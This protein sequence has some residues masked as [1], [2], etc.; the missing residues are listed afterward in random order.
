MKRN[1]YLTSSSPA[2]N[3]RLVPLLGGNVED[4]VLVQVALQRLRVSSLRHVITAHNTAADLA[5][6][7]VSAVFMLQV[8]LDQGSD[9]FYLQIGPFFDILPARSAVF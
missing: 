2:A 4:S 6:G 1:P 5:T 9:G 3:R 8:D 7:Y